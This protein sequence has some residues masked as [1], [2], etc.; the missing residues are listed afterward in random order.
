M[1][2][3][4]ENRQLTGEC[5]QSRT[6]HAYELSRGTRSRVTVHR[7]VNALVE[8]F[9]RS[10]NRLPSINHSEEQRRE[11]RPHECATPL[12]STH[13]CHCSDCDQDMNNEQDY[14][15]TRETCNILRG[16]HT[17]Q[18]VLCEDQRA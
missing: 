2:S 5:E 16:A 4:A 6:V 13:L 17:L 10:T 18:R 8:I 15:R 1:A 11:Q 9:T 14:T 3:L 12:A 7:L